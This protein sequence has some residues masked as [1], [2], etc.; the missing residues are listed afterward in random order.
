MESS[1]YKC[2]RFTERTAGLGHGNYGQTAVQKGA[3]SRSGNVISLS[4]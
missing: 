3:A 4:P 1:Y 2:D